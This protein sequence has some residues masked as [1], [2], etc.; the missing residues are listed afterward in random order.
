MQNKNNEDTKKK[1]EN[2]QKQL[3]DKNACKIIANKLKEY[4]KKP[5][6]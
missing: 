4:I 2:M 6:K 3:L 5:S 1:I